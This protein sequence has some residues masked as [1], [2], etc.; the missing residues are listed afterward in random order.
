MGELL[1]LDQK[2]LLAGAMDQVKVAHGRLDQRQCDAPGRGVRLKSRPELVDPVFLASEAPA[3]GK[4]GDVSECGPR[5]A[6]KLEVV[7]RIQPDRREHIPSDPGEGLPAVLTRCRRRKAIQDL[8]GLREEPRR[9]DKRAPFGRIQAQR[10]VGEG[11]VETVVE[12]GLR[13]RPGPVS[14]EVPVRD[15]G[16]LVLVHGILDDEGGH[17]TLFLLVVD[18]VVVP[19]RLLARRPNGVDHLDVQGQ[20]LLDFAVGCDLEYSLGDLGI[21]QAMLFPHQS[22]IHRR[23]LKGENEVA[24]VSADRV[25]DETFDTSCTGPGDRPPDLKG[26]EAGL[27]DRQDSLLLL[28]VGRQEKGVVYTSRIEAM[29]T[30]GLPRR[31]AK[32]I[33][34]Y[35]SVPAVQIR[36]AW[37]QY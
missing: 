37:L 4:E 22:T 30:A 28:D 2:H 33:Q 35:L 14:I 36:V 31:N 8:E 9:H 16:D 13:A 21:T 20:D 12:T 15:H 6:S 23:S 24:E 10:S 3:G 7:V 17:L 18:L 32:Y 29:L 26:Q 19:V 11:D 25:R 27:I 1:Q 34:I 5:T